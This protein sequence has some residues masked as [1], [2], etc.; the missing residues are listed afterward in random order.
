MYHFCGAE[1]TKW[2]IQVFPANLKTKAVEMKN[3]NCGDLGFK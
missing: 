3:Q 2:I 1:K